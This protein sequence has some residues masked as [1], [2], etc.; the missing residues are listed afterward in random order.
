MRVVLLVNP[1]ASSVSPG[2]QYA[3]ADALAVRHDLEVVSTNARDHA[4]E[5]AADATARGAEVVVV[6]AGD[7][8]LNETAQGLAGSHTALAPLPGGSTNVFA[9]SLG[10]AFSPLDACAQLLRSLDERREQRIGLGVATSQ[11]VTRRFVFHLGLGF[12]AAVVRQMEERLMG[13]KR[14]LAHP[15]FAVATVDTWMRHYDRETR[16]TLTARTVKGEVSSTTGPYAV[17]SNADP[18]TYVGH[19]PV[20]LAPHAGIERPLAVTVFA[21]LR[22]GLLVR[23]AGG[24]LL[25]SPSIQASPQITQLG[26]VEEVVVSA[27]R[28][29]PWQVDGDHLGDAQELVVRYE[30]DALTVIV[31]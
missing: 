4:S 11:G 30:P 14:H 5:L 3:I 27:D 29:V 15:A 16:I 1:A 8:T 20:S 23:A 25:H 19:R 9:R 21:S 24:G 22:V 12:D 26:D 7:G 10:I 2:T 18:Y 17:V 28:P 31:P 13:L 6:L